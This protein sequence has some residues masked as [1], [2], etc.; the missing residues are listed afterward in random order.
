[1]KD[2]KYTN[3]LRAAINRSKVL[4]DNAL[5]LAKRTEVLKIKLSCMRMYHRNMR[6][7]RE[8]EKQILRYS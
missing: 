7:I 8:N 2:P 4:A 1:M 3:Q 5:S 6:D